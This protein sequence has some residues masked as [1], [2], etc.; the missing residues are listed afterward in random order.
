MDR[1]ETAYPFSMNEVY[2][3]FIPARLFGNVFF[4]FHALPFVPPAAHV[5][6]FRV[7]SVYGAIASPTELTLVMEFVE[8]GSIRT[9]S[10]C[11]YAE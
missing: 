9:V 8:R 7:V 10:A 2:F 11:V 6:L 4:L 5:F 1:N 3:V